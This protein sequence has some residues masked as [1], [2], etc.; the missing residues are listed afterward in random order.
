MP[1]GVW[2]ECL[3]TY[4]SSLLTE[5]VVTITYIVELQFKVCALLACFMQ[6]QQQLYLQSWK[7]L[8]DKERSYSR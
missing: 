7:D 6:D 5:Y 2:E 4:L 3:A 1:L 8:N